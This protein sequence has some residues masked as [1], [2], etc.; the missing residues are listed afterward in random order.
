MA[1]DPT[2]PQ[3]VRP[4]LV[5]AAV[6]A[7]SL[8]VG[9]LSDP[10]AAQIIDFESIPAGTPAGSGC[11]T[12]GTS[13]TTQGFTFSAVSFG[14]N[15]LVSCDGTDPGLGSNGTT[16]LLDNNAAPD[17]DFQTV[18]GAAF[19]LLSLD[20]S[21]LLTNAAL[22]RN[23]TQIGVG[24]FPVAGGSIVATFNLDGIVDGPGGSAD[25]QT[26]TLPGT[27]TNLTKAK[28]TFTQGGLAG[29]EFLVDNINVRV[30]PTPSSAALGLV[31]VMGLNVRRR[32]AV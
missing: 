15:G 25:F 21:E 4:A 6:L 31:T 26:F 16:T 7:A 10:V 23:A 20:V 32:R 18:S 13:L 27:F 5:G 14:S 11:A 30:I 24:G 28:I 22:S 12:H 17:I 19:D 2:Q 3:R 9:A 29:S 1:I 8:S